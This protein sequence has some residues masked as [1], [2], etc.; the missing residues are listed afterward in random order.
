MQI[1]PIP[2]AALLNGRGF[3]RNL[4]TSVLKR[5]QRFLCFDSKRD[6][7]QKD[8]STPAKYY[9]YSKNEST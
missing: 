6:A 3:K 8:L 5:A 7:E 9:F 2:S 1:A 4:N